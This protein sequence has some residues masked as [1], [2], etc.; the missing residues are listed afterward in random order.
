M[1]QV[2]FFFLLFSCAA[3]AQIFHVDP[4]ATA[5]MYVWGLMANTANNGH[6]INEVTP[7]KISD[8]AAS[9]VSVSASHGLMIVNGELWVW[10]VQSNGRLGNGSTSA[11]YFPITRIGTETDWTH[12]SAGSSQS[13]A[14]RAGR[15]YVTGA[16]TAGELGRGNNTQVSTWTQ[17]G[18]DTNWQDVKAGNGWALAIKGGSLFTTGFG[19]N[20]RTGLNS[21]GDVNT[22]TLASSAETFTE[23]SA[24]STHGIAIGGGKLYSWGSNANGRTGQGIT[25]GETQVPTQ[26]GSDTNWAKCAAGLAHAMC[27]KTT[28]TLWGFGSG[29]NG[30]LGTGNSTQQT[31]PVQ[32]GS[33]TDWSD[34]RGTWLSGVNSYARKTN[35]YLYGCGTD[36]Q[37]QLFGL[38]SYTALNSNMIQ[39]TTYAVLDY[40]MEGHGIFSRN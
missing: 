17:I 29:T 30:R 22:W 9:V 26:V 31:S 23:I 10:G 24:A 39:L 13:Y 35:G 15:L 27:T 18:S 33:D 38:G 3:Q 16:N 8:K 4:A 32:A 34:V 2:L 5:G 14:I 7:V 25:T 11:S 21:T 40:G 28:G 20:F 1:K 37:G 36:A 12:V 6:G 19:Q